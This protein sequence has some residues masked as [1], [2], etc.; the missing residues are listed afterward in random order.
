MAQVLAVT[1]KRLGTTGGVA[2]ILGEGII[3]E[4]GETE[5]TEKGKKKRTV[6]LALLGGG[7]R[8][9]LVIRAKLNDELVALGDGLEPY[10]RVR[11]LGTYKTFQIEGK[12][13]PVI[14]LYEIERTPVAA[15]RPEAA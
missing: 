8:E 9:P 10:Q 15:A 1:A 13:W 12:T 6:T 3:S 2:I 7:S 4:V 5:I 11:F 14:S